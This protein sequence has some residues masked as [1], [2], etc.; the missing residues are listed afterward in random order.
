MFLILRTFISKT[1]TVPD[2]PGWLVTLPWSPTPPPQP[3]LLS[4]LPDHNPKPSLPVHCGLWVWGR[5]PGKD[6]PLSPSLGLLPLSGWSE[7]SPCGPC[8]PPSLLAA[9]SRTALEEHWPWDPAGLSPTPA[10]MLASEQHRHRLCLDPET[11]RPWAGDPD[12]CTVPLS[13]Q[14]LCP[15]PG[16]CQGNGEGPGVG[17]GRGHLVCI[18]VLAVSWPG[19]GNLCHAAA[20]SWGKA[21]GPGN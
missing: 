10:S 5:V 17:W 21:G 9:A 13:Q 18:I 3:V 2:K 12:L 1:G 11:G 14:R 6:A 19:A 8:L 4:D 20:G 7:W 15:D 16:A